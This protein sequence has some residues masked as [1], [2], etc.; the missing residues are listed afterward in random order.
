MAGVLTWALPTVGG[1]PV[2]ETIIKV[3]NPDSDIIFGVEA[4][5]KIHAQKADNTI[6]LPYEYVQTDSTGDYV[7]V[8]AADSTVQR[9][10]VVIGISTSTDAQITE[11]L[12]VGDKVITSDVSNLTEGMVVVAQ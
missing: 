12:E 10:D 4:S 5:N 9:K 11:G 7:Y 1:Q 2:V 6:V 8:L 3:L